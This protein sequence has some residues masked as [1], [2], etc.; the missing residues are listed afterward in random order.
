LR[1]CVGGDIGN[2]MEQLTTVNKTQ[3]LMMQLQCYGFR[4]DAETSALWRRGVRVPFSTC[5]DL[6]AGF[7]PS[8][9]LNLI[10][11]LHTQADADKLASEARKA[12][13]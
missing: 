4:V 6:T 3:A 12:V 8:I 9:A 1:C 11:Q 13:N 5:F 7:C 2:G 10:V